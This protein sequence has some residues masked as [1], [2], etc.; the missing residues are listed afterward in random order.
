MASAAGQ[1]SHASQTKKT[2][3][4]II[5]DTHSAT[6]HDDGDTEH[7]FRWPLPEADILIHCGD[8]TSNGALYQHERTVEMIKKAPAK[9]KIVIPG[10]HDITLD[11]IYYAR[12]WKLHGAASGKQDLRAIRNL[13]T[14]TEAEEAG[15]VYL[16]EGTQTF[17]VNGAKLTVY[18]SAYTPEFCNWAFAYERD[19]DRFS[20]QSRSINPVADH[21]EIDIMVT[22]G[23]PFGILDKT[24]Q[25]VHVGC[26]NLFSAVWRCRPRLHAFGHIHEAWGAVR[27]DWASLV[28]DLIVVPEKEKLVRDGGAF[29]DVSKEGGMPLEFGKDTLFVNASIMNLQYNPTNAPFIVDLDLPLAEP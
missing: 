13:Y 19:Q 26:E 14:S 15:L 3:I 22:H 1:T 21:G 11:E 17:N 10:N 9:L 24:E 5:S 6:P 20:Y 18:A 16:V 27:T 29:V 28:G 7:A 4:L 2:R 12:D 25:G 8:L 23:P